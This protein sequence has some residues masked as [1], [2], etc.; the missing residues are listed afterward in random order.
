MHRRHLAIIEF[1][2]KVLDGFASI[3][4]RLERIEAKLDDWKLLQAPPPGFSAG[5]K[6]HQHPDLDDVQE[7]VFGR[8]AAFPHAF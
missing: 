1:Q 8:E 5:C 4:G 2:N 6:I 7:R 3:V